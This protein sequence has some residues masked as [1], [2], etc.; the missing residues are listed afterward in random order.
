MRVPT[1]RSSARRI[2][3][4]AL[5]ALLLAQ[6][7]ALAHAVLHAAQVRPAERA[8]AATSVQADLFGHAAGA[9]ECRLVDQL[10]SF[11]GAP[12]VAPAPGEPPAATAP[13]APRAGVAPRGSGHPYEARAPPRA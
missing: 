5:L 13:P 4:V 11:A 1:A 9:R 12:D 8:A 10:L 7:V 3:G 6:W 2:V